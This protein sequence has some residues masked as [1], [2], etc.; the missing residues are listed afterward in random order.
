[1]TSL[2]CS[3]RSLWIRA[4]AASSQHYNLQQ[5]L[6]FAIND[7]VKL[8]DVRTIFQAV[9]ENPSGTQIAWRELQMSWPKLVKKFG[10]V[11]DP[12][13]KHCNSD[14]CSHSVRTKRQ[15][16]RVHATTEEQLQSF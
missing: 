1:M 15:V 5:Y 8:Q 2:F 13:R 9:A 3:E 14:E 7:K 16:Y 4:L 12:N 11:I 10:E 6:H